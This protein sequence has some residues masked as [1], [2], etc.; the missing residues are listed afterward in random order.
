MSGKKPTTK[1]PTTKRIKPIVEEEPKQKEP[2]NQDVIIGDP[3]MFEVLH[4]VI[5][6]DDKLLRIT[7]AMQVRGGCV[8]SMT[9]RQGNPDDSYALAE[10]L[11]FVPNV[12]ITDDVNG[13][14][15]LT[16]PKL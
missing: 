4:S 3:D 9:T 6:P 16:Q 13:G 14:K 11:T 2:T 8:L 12:W 7:S 5:S 1:K 15:K 10:S